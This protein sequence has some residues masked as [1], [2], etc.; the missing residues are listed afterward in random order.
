[1]KVFRK[2]VLLKPDTIFEAYDVW[3]LSRGKLRAKIRH[4]QDLSFIKSWIRSVFI[5][6]EMNGP[7]IWKPSSSIHLRVDL[8]NLRSFILSSY[9]FIIYNSC[10]FPTL[11]CTIILFIWAG[12]L[13]VKRE[14]DIGDVT[15]F[16]KG[17]RRDA[18]SAVLFLSQLSQIFSLD[19]LKS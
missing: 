8:G 2:W 12:N 4:W 14:F 11:I 3:N 9:Q 17:E 1:M 19:L 16:P 6:N 7:Q 5:Y 13:V 15:S 18:T 10:C